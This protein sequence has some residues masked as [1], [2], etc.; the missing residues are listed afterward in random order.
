[1]RP[2]KVKT[3]KYIPAL[4]FGWLTPLYDPILRWVMREEKFKKELVRQAGF[5]MAVAV[6]HFSTIFGTLTLY[7]AQKQGY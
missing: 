3:E 7:R 2:I 5:D 6:R 1:M 4:R